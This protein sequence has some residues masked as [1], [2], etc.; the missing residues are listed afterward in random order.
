ML[1]IGPVVCIFIIPA[2]KHYHTW[3]KTSSDYGTLT[4]E[5][6]FF[7]ILNW[8]IVMRL[9]IEIYV[10]E[11]SISLV[12]LW[13]VLLLYWSTS[14]VNWTDFAYCGN[15]LFYT[16]FY[17]CSREINKKKNHGYDHVITIT[18]LSSLIGQWSLAHFLWIFLF[19]LCVP[20]WMSVF[21]N[22]FNL[23]GWLPLNACRYFRANT[24]HCGMGWL[25]EV[26]R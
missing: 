11:A 19:S 8:H 26:W 18:W 7:S 16:R 10:Q 25:A 15:I 21:V 13:D 24:L 14:V 3:I 22:Y 1:S 17:S 9:K 23:K 5:F 20:L 2:L 4:N 12:Y 6:S